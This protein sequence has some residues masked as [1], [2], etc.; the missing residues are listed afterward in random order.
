M[1]LKCF[2]LGLAHRGHCVL[3]IIGP[4]AARS[5][6]PFPLAVPL[7]PSGYFEVRGKAGQIPGSVG[8]PRETEAV[9]DSQGG[10]PR[11]PSYLDPADDG[12]RAALRGEPPAPGAAPPAAPRLPAAGER[13]AQRAGGDPEPQG[14]EL[15]PGLG[16]SAASCL[17]PPPFAFL[18]SFPTRCRTRSR[19][20]SLPIP[21][22]CRRC[23][24]SS[25]DCRLCRLR[26][27]G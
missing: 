8:V 12:E 16:V 14:A 7:R 11:P 13:G 3:V 24:R 23:C 22:P 19:S 27:P 1:H 17:L 21:A 10:G 4:G 6:V 2:E 9:G 25:R 20:P 5:T 15:G 18:C 26:P